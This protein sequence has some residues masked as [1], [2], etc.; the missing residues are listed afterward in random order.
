MHLT[1]FRNMVYMGTLMGLIPLLPRLE[2]R[3]EK[4]PATK[5]V[6]QKFTL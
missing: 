2:A 6:S 4:A 1:Y 3:E 5:E